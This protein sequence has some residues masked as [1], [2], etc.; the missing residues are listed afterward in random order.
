[1]I[2]IK[3]QGRGTAY[4]PDQLQ[5]KY[6]IKPIQKTYTKISFKSVQKL[7]NKDLKP[8][9][10]LALTTSEDKLFQLLKILKI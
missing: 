8:L 9:I 7:S 1:M 6:T 4:L 10:D 5:R 3:I 2:M